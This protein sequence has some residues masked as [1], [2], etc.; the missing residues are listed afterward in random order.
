MKIN[1]FVNIYNFF[2]LKIEHLVFKNFTVLGKLLVKKYSGLQRI[3]V[4]AY[5][6]S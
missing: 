3:N 1:K 2:L 4:D 5:R 6:V